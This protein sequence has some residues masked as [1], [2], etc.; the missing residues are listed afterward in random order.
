MIAEGALAD[1]FAAAG[2]FDALGG[3]FVGFKFW[4]SVP[5]LL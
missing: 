2:D 3:A 5:S 4:H 1:K